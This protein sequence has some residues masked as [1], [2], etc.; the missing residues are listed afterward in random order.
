MY[1]RQEPIDAQ[2]LGDPQ[3]HI[4]DPGGQILMA[5][6]DGQVVGTCALKS[7]PGNELEL[8][9]MAVDPSAQGQGIGKQLIQA[10]IDYFTA[11]NAQRLWLETN[12]I[13]TTAIALYEK[14]G[15][16]RIGN[17]PRPGSRYQRSDYYMQWQRNR[18]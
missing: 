16:V 4:I 15:F 8:T 18:V 7:H 1:K 2:V 13:L 6:L 10:S 17:G 11:E 12:H 3:T 9:K 5:S 14:F